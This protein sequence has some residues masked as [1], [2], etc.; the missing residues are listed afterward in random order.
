[1]NFVYYYHDVSSGAEFEKTIR[2]ITRKYKI[3]SARELYDY[4]CGK[5]SLKN[6]CVFTIDD[7]WLSTYKYVFPVIKKFNIPITIFVSPKMVKEAGNFWYYLFDYCNQNRVKDALFND[8]IITEELKSFPLKSILKELEVETIYK[9]LHQDVG[10]SAPRGFIDYNELMDLNSC[11]LVTI[12]A[13]T[14]MHPILHN[15]SDERAK[16][17]IEQSVRELSEI[18]GKPV[19][20]FAYPNGEYGL[21]F[22]ERE[23][24]YCKEAGIEMAFSTNPGIVKPG[25]EL[26]N[27]SRCGSLNRLKLGILG[28]LIPTFGKQR[29]ERKKIRSILCI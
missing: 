8:N 1:M 5:T 4:L 25:C 29:N 13:H 22:T 24:D 21:D 3:V 17:E 10:D 6:S 28:L 18:L 9:Y 12:G 7:G 19:T 2:T 26:M 16:L 11:P 15:E 14:M 23:M 27:I 20:T